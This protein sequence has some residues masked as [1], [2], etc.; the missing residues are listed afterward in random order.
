MK[1]KGAL[2]F[3]SLSFW[4]TKAFPLLEL[5]EFSCVAVS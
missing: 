1:W 4:T 3:Y 5:V 2:L